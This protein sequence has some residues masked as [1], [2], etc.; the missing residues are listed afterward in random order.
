M[1]LDDTD[2]VTGTL[3]VA[4]GGTNLASGTSGGIL[5][6]TAS[7]TLASS[8]ALTANQIVL[9]GGA[10]A[11]PIPLGSTGTTSQVLIGNASG[12]PSWGTL[13][14][15]TMTTGSLGP[16]TGGTGLTSYTT[17][18]LIQATAANTL[19]A[20]A[21]VSAGSF[22]RSGGVGT[23]NAWSTTKWPNSATAGDL[24]YASG[25]NQYANLTAG[26]AGTYLRGAGAGT[27]PV[28]STL[29]LPN[30]A[31]VGDLPIATSSNTL[32]ML[33]AVATGRV[34]ISSGVATAPAWSTTPI[35][36]TF[37]ASG[38]F[39]GAGT[40]ATAGAVRLANTAAIEARNA[41][42]GAD[43]ILVA[44]TADD[45]IRIGDLFTS[46]HVPTISSGFGTTPAI[47]GVS[48]AFKVTV[49]SGGDTTGVVL[50]NTTWPHAPVCVAN[51]ETSAQ[52]VR[53]TPTTTQVTLA[54]TLGAAD[55]LSVWCA[56]Y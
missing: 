47:A 39:N 28:W 17:G 2:A 48:S 7:G 35:A 56:A 41:A 9:G 55:V 10:G 29:V 5:G 31:T 23:A 4:S 21:G 26:A 8:V 49:G 12:A 24:L 6:F 18:D 33:T 15:A 14:I 43:L 3:G 34:L 37:T 42:N 40:V 1:D 51:N 27:P 11:T 25:A 52:L 46:S 16:T 36:T 38:S 30:G 54:G 50:F 19:S 53:A 44:S 32:T 22:L 20:L 45:H 13:N